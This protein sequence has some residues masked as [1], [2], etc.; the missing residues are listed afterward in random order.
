MN[1]NKY[2]D[3]IFRDITTF[4]GFVFYCLIMLLALI[5]QEFTLFFKLLFGIIFTTIV[6][7]LI[8]TF[9]FKNR[10]NKQEYGNFIDK[11]D[12]SSFPSWHTA[13]IVFLA[14]IFNYFFS[15]NNI[16]NNNDTQNYLT[17]LFF[18]TALLVAYSRIYLK[19]HDWKDVVGGIVLGMLTFLLSNLMW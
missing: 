14:L 4:G 15:H 17:L 12:A 19:K 3:A 6:I 5:F 9:Y 13:K 11:I 8:R 1:K 2:L 18:I 10:P 16:F 7:V